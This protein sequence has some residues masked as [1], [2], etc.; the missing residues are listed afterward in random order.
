MATLEYEGYIARIETDEDNNGFHGRVINIS[1]VINFKGRSMAEL[2]REFANSIRE[3]FAFCK[4]RGDAPEQPFSGK[5]VL[6]VDPAVHRA[7]TRAAERD[8]VSINKW[9][10]EQLARAA[11]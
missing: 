2:K 11:G 1:D 9:A 3:Y 4:E 8:G 5:F 6:R 10:E 7:I